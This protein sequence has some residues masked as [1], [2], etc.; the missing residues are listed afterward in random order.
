MWRAEIEPGLLRTFR[1]FAGLE[2]IF[3]LVVV[4]FNWLTGWGIRQPAQNFYFINLGTAVILL[5]YLS[6]RWLHTHLGALYLPLALAQVTV[7][8]ILSN[9]I[10]LDMTPASNTAAPILN[11][12]QWMPMLFVPLV[13]IA[14]QYD[15]TAVVAFCLVT[16]YID[17]TMVLSFAEKF[18]LQFLP[19]LSI[20]IIRTVSFIVVGY[21]VTRLM[22]TQREQRQ[23]LLQANQ[24]LA[25]HSATLQ[26]L[27]VSRE[28]NRLAR[29][30]HD[31]LA[32]TLSGLA[33]HLEATKTSLDPAQ[34]EILGMLEHALQVTRNGLMETRRAL[35]DLRA[36]QLDD[37]GLS[38]ALVN[39]ADS[40][41]SRTALPVDV[42]VPANL[43]LPQPLEQGVYRIAQEALENVARHAGASRVGFRVVQT[44]NTFHM[45]IE[46]DGEGF[47]PM[48]AHEED[49]FGLRGM[50]EW[51]ENIGGR[52]QIHSSSGQGTRV[53]LDLEIP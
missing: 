11:A 42:Q 51:A 9:R 20:S 39:L 8:P 53:I 18:S 2:V 10:F 34:G 49:H 16:G 28:R 45:T 12:W 29:E 19:V 15:L 41:T 33:V 26:Q 24:Q 4:A 6:W 14:W 30:L 3:Y 22:K 44:A 40:F 13:L 1:L 35:K 23:A 21:I 47:D 50:R 17:L 25:Q 38:I 43:A 5:G 32:H 27:A 37:I 52:L 31:T 36:T 48:A 46:D 7:I